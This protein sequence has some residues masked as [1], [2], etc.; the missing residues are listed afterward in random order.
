MTSSTGCGSATRGQLRRIDAVIKRKR[1]NLS[2]LVVKEL[3]PLGHKPKDIR[4]ILACAGT[5]L[6]KEIGNGREVEWYRVLVARAVPLAQRTFKS[7]LPNLKG[8][9]PYE[10]A[11]RAKI[12][13]EARAAITCAL[14]KF[15]TTKV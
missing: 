5:L 4:R 10:S 15:A 7:N 3:A 8:K 9:P 14:D 2:D 11:C 6:A 13:V 12:V 1:S